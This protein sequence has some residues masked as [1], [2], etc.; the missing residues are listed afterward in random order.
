MLRM[1]QHLHRC[2]NTVPEVFVPD[3]CYDGYL[4]RF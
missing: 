4:K 1:V 3:V 2:T